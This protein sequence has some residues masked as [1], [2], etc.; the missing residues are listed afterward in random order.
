MKPNAFLQI[1]WANILMLI[2]DKQGL[3]WGLVMPVAILIIISL[4]PLYRLVSTNVPYGTFA[5]PG[6]VAMTIMQGGIYSLAYWLIDIR[7]RGVL[8]RFAVTPIR[9]W[10]LFTG[11]LTARLIIIL[12]QVIALTIVGTVVFNAEVNASQIIPALVFAIVGGALFLLSGLLVATFAQSY[13]AAA[14]IT[15]SIGLP[16]TFL[17]GIFF[18]LAMLPEILQKIANVLPIT[19]LAS[20]IRDAFLSAFDLT[21]FVYRLLIMLAWLLVVAVVVSWRFK[22]VE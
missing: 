4:L 21:T 13:D 3:F 1:V 16:F 11:V 2:R 12:L 10:T 7:A 15:A 9:P 6:L 20:G 18:P 8:K 5:L 14:P 22:L 17:G 19:A